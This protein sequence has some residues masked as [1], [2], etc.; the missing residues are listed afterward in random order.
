VARELAAAG[1]DLVL[2]DCP[3]LTLAGAR[4]A[5]IPSLALC[6]LNWADIFRHY[7]AGRPGAA[8]IHRQQV[9]AYQGADLFLRTEPSMPMDWLHNGRDIGPVA[10]PGRNRRHEIDAILGSRG[11]RLVLVGL[12]GIPMRL[13]LE[14]WPRIEGVRWLVQRDWGVTRS[15]AV[16]LESLAM[17][18]TDLLASSDLFLT[19]PGYGSFTEAACS[20]VPVLYLARPGWPESPYLE[21]W[22]E[23]HGRGLCLSPQGLERGAATAPM[24][25]LLAQGRH[26][27]VAPDGV[28]QAAELIG[29]RLL[30]GQGGVA[31]SG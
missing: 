28:A 8:A 12:G 1:P 13:P 21:R 29:G 6:C 3:Y 22:L 24:A 14:R 7:F 31:V 17:S 20:G 30:R 27:P 9:A 4:L 2:A 26:R 25:R 15:D 23:A 16:E 11:E 10:A 18:F 5:E 19:K